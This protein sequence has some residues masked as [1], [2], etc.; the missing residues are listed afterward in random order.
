M[1]QPNIIFIQSDKHR[2][3]ALAVNG[4]T[5]AITPNLDQLAADGLNFTHAFCPVPICCPARA[6]LHCGVWPHQHQQVA[7]WD[8]D[9]SRPHKP[10]RTMGQCLRDAGYHLGFLDKWHV[11]KNKNPDHEDYGFHEV[12]ETWRY[13]QWRKDQGLP[14]LPRPK[15]GFFEFYYG[16]VDEDAGPEQTR[17][18][19][20]ADKT[21]DMLQ[22]FNQQDKP[23]AIFWEPP[24]P[25]LPCY[26][27]RHWMD[28]F[29]EKEM[30]PWPGAHDDLHGKPF[31]QRQQ[32]MDWGVEHWNWEENWN[33]FVTRYFAIIAEL[34]HQIGRV[35]AE[36]DALGLRENTIV[37]YTTDH[38]D[39]TGDHG[40][41]DQHY[42]LYDCVFRVPMIVRW[43][44]QIQ[45][46]RSTDE[47]TCNALDISRTLIE[48]AGGTVPESFT[49]ESLLPLFT[50]TGG[51]GREDIYGQYQNNQ[52]G[53]CSQRCVRDRRWKYIWTATDTDELYDLDSDPG[54]VNNLVNESQYAHE[55]Q[56]LRK[57]LIT[58]MEQENDPMINPW[59][60]RQLLEGRKAQ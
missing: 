17:L 8:S 44:E 26:P 39:S 55:L 5:M 19:W 16:G 10:M 47:F 34:D 18:H 37:V 48:A 56:R 36:L 29:K 2:Y 53:L 49:G 60:K 7:N 27:S 40:L 57:R 11:H 21:I 24:E 35:L 4:H 3:D 22:R 52:F 1:T 9:A 45:A 30:P 12:A 31:G 54:E 20:A 14:P 42:I 43:P 25:H 50:D 38:G 46:G 13:P 33:E 28:M 23:F 51:T 59:T 58:W 32:Q 41:I 15:D 6:S